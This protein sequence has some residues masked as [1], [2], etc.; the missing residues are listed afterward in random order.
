MTYC[1][2]CGR[3]LREGISFCPECGQAV[4]TP[5]K[6]VNMQDAI[7][8]QEYSPNMEMPFLQPVD[9]LPM[10]YGN[11]T[12]MT[13]YPA[14]PAV[15]LGTN[16][17]L[18]KFVLLSI[19][20]FGIYAIITFSK[21][22]R[23][24]NTIASKYDGRKTMH[25]CLIL[26]LFSWLTLG[27]VPLIWGSRLSRRIGN[28]LKRRGIN[29]GFGAGTYWGWGVFGSLIIV[30]FFLYHHKLFTAMNLLAEDYNRRG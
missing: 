21:L 5:L 28:E 13:Q 10:T 18:W 14:A 11:M 30:G 2:N 29:Y 19:V 25:Y 7:G 3:E 12:P 20:T 17:S 24:I 26:F 6:T 8:L 1:I 23:D 9:Q 4:R 15:K 22:S 27:I 16:R